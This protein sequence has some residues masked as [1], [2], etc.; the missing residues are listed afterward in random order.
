MIA[1]EATKGAIIG[2]VAGT[3]IAVA[4]IPTTPAI[5]LRNFKTGPR[6]PQSAHFCAVASS[7]GSKPERVLKVS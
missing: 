5:L 6:T 4:T 7:A 3:A 2:A 1:D